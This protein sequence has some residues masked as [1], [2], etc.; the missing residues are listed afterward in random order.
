MPESKIPPPPKN[1]IIIA[2][3]DLL[4]IGSWIDF[5]KNLSPR[6]IVR[7]PADEDFAEFLDDRQIILRKKKTIAKEHRLIGWPTEENIAFIIEINTSRLDAVILTFE[8]DEKY[9]F[10]FDDLAFSLGHFQWDGEGDEQTFSLRHYQRTVLQWSYITK[11]ITDRV[12]RLANRIP[13]PPPQS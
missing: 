4:R 13:A 2:E 11:L 3:L 7:L 1:Q 5:F 9:F 10:C 8:W 6:I 12:E